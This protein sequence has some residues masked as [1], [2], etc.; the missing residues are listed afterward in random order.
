MNSLPCLTCLKYPV[1]KHKP[2][3][4]CTDLIEWLVED[5]VE[6]EASNQ[7]INIYEAWNDREISFITVQSSCIYFKKGK[8]HYSCLIATNA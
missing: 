4:E 5:G 8:D 2:I 3:I 6:T 1:C 7:R